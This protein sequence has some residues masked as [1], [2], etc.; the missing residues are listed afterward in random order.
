MTLE[1]LE[2]AIER[3]L[4]RITAEPDYLPHHQAAFELAR[5]RKVAGG[6]RMSSVLW[7]R[8]HKTAVERMVA[9]ER[10]WVRNVLDLSVLVR[11]IQAVN[12]VA[13]DDATRD[14]SPVVDW[15]RSTAQA[16]RGVGLP[17]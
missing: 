15:L 17:G 3:L 10:A 13:E 2:Q 5:G 8:R 1:E 11:L 7:P 12:S 6:K 4:G 16:M 9:M 14:M